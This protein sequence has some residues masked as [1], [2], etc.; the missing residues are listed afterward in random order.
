[1]IEVPPEIDFKNEKEEYE[2]YYYYPLPMAIV[3]MVI[4][5]NYKSMKRYIFDKIKKVAMPY[6]L[7]F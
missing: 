5:D 7:D 3:I 1:M 6:I 4:L 2:Y